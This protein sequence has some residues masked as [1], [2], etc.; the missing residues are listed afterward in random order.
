MNTEIINNNAFDLGAPPQMIRSPSYDDYEVEQL[1]CDG[2]FQELY[3]T[4]N[5][6]VMPEPCEKCYIFSC[7]GMCFE[8]KEK[9]N[10]VSQQLSFEEEMNL[11]PPS[12]PLT[13]IKTNAHIPDDILEN[14]EDE[15]EMSPPK[16]SNIMETNTTDTTQVAI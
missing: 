7:N 11:L 12:Q 13:R 10:L 3:N 16:T 2:S 4:P 9:I 1:I 8:E 14:E 5:N 15:I 6:F